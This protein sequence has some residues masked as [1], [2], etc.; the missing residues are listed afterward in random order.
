LAFKI[1]K[2][3]CISARWL[4]LGEGEMFIKKEQGRVEF[5]HMDEDEILRTFPV[6]NHQVPAGFPRCP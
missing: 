2:K 5:A 3:Y 6:I 4:L 1:E